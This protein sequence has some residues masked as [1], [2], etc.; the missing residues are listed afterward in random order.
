MA[1]LVGSAQ[2]LTPTMQPPL[3]WPS[4]SC[5]LCAWAPAP[6]N[7]NSAAAATLL[8]LVPFLRAAQVSA[9]A[10]QQPWAAFQTTRKT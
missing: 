2:V 8:A 6:A 9:T 7:T 10:T 4:T 5:W 3:P 1:L